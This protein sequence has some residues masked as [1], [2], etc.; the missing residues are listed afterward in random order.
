MGEE[1]SWLISLIFYCL[2]MST[3]LPWNFF[4]NVNGYWMYKFRTVS[5]G[6][7]DTSVA[8]DLNHLQVEFMS[9]LSNAAMIPNVT[10]LVLNG[11][12]GHRF[13]MDRRYKKIILL[14]YFHVNTIFTSQ[15]IALPGNGRGFLHRH[16]Q[17]GQD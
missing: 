5:N 9:Y 16:P 1:R 3:L 15:V 17:L 7:N 10:F 12:I 2:A 14:W 4:I 11:I 6:T 13:R 8:A